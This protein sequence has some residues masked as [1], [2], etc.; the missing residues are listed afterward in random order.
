MRLSHSRRAPG[1]GRALRELLD[2]SRWLDNAVKAMIELLDE[3]GEHSSLQLAIAGE[4]VVKVK[5][6]CLGEPPAARWTT[7]AGQG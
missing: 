6:H 3:D 1:D 5:E 7:E 4:A 2:R